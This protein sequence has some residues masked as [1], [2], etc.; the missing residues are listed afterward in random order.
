MHLCLMQTLL[1][2]LA[3]KMHLDKECDII[4][5]S[6]YKLTFIASTGL[7]LFSIKLYVDHTYNDISRRASLK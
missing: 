5:L 7:I 4:N 2:F 6:E 3:F 1:I